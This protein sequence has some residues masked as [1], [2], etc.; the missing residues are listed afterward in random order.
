MGL[1]LRLAWR[2]LRARPGQ[3]VLLL[4]VLSLSTTTV[5]LGLAVNETGDES[6]DRLHRSMNGFHVLVT[7]VYHPQAWQ[8][9]V[10]PPAP[11]P[12]DAARVDATLAALARE[13]GVA[14]VSGPWPQL[15]TEGR[16]ADIQVQIRV[17]VRDATPAAVS[18]PL[19]TSG[20][21]LADGDDGIVL[22]DGFAS[23][24]KVKPGDEVTIAGQRLRVRGSATT[25]SVW[26]YPLDN[27]AMIWANRATAAQLRAAG[28]IPSGAMLELRLARPEQANALV[29]AGNAS[30]LVRIKTLEQARSEAGENLGVFLVL[31]I[32]ATLLSGL[33]VATAAVLVTGRMTAQSRQIG[34][35]KAVGLTPRQ[36]LAVV[37]VEYLTIA[38]AAAGIG[39][40]AGTL[41]SPLMVQGMP[42][43][44]GAPAPPPL[45]WPRAI[46]ALT[47]AVAVVI[48][49]SLNPALRGVRQSTVRALA[50]TARP[51]RRASRTARLA[52]NVGVPLPVALGIRAA[53]RRPGRTIANA[54]GLALGVAMVIVGLGADRA[55]HDFLDS[56]P[57]DEEEA[58]SRTVNAI[59]IDQLLD[60]V[61]AASVLLIALAT[62]NALIVA[63]FAARDNARNHAIMRAVGAT[64]RQTVISFVVAQSGACLLGCAI[65]IPLGVILYNA[66]TTSGQREVPTIALNVSVYILVAVAALLLYLLAVI[67][68]A[69]RL[70][71]RPVAG[72]LTCE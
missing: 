45:T 23:L 28:A 13:P 39:I 42:N 33:T 52:A 66:A 8:G 16:V 51:P 44:Y 29:A 21:W 43:L 14:A 37:L 58:I 4:L 54:I 36:A 7:A 46:A 27:P 48:V 49:G 59:L 1:I 26:H 67:V 64:P 57:R 35:L 30:G 2:N 25:T 32:I 72:V 40:I 68:P 31:L 12:A 47:V 22:E 62:L 17:Q 24:F 34:T 60:M 63:I 10:T 65:G 41:L 5:G 3:A 18:Q 56:A 38:G 6:W 9:L 69:A 50:S 70:A 53:L 55:A 11:D 20:A 61:L 71:R 19:I 15:R